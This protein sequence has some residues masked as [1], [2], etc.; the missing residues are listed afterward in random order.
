MIFTDYEPLIAAGC[1]AVHIT[2]PNSVYDY[3]ATAFDRSRVS[4]AAVD[5]AAAKLPDEGPP[6]VLDI[7]DFDLRN[8]FARAVENLKLALLRWKSAKPR[9][10]LGLYGLIPERNFWT[11]VRHA[12]YLRDS[13]LRE[14]FVWRDNYAIWRARNDRA[15]AAIVP[16]VDALYPSIYAL[17]ARYDEWWS[18][19]ADANLVEAERIAG[20]RPVYPFV[21]PIYKGGAAIAAS[22]W[23]TMLE[24]CCMHPSS[25]GPVVFSAAARKVHNSWVQAVDRRLTPAIPISK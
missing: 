2:G 18:M 21:Q 6:I 22:L 3:A 15:A 7:E 24:C 11:P 10:S 4:I 9:R 23:D 5:R 16:Y 19:Y 14:W 20:G 17:D 12:M 1:A 13:N 8:D 25:S